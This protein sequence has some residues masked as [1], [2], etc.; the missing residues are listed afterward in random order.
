MSVCE[1]RIVP[2]GVPVSSVI[3]PDPQ[4]M[5]LRSGGQFVDVGQARRS[6]P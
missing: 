6:A 1:H 2:A 4:H 5:P 3:E